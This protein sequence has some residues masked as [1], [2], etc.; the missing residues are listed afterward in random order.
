[1]STVSLF[2]GSGWGA[3]LVCW[4]VSPL[5]C[6]DL[7][8]RQGW[9]WGL[10]LCGGAPFGEEI[11]NVS[12][13]AA[14]L[15]WS[16]VVWQPVFVASI[17]ATALP[18]HACVCVGR[19]CDRVIGLCWFP[20]TVWQRTRLWRGLAGVQVVLGWCRQRVRVSR[21]A[22]R[23]LCCLRAAFICDAYS[24]SAGVW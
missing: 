17:G 1:V 18:V 22:A 15:C 5:V 8:G 23:L 9:G 21:V 13:N 11:G 2:G 10:F 16:L 7:L 20:F 24:P 3:G 6:V 14:W 19:V 4:F 12:L